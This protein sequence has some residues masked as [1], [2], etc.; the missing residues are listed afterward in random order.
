MSTVT[1]VSGS[2][3]CGKSTL[4]RQLARRSGVGVHL[5]TDEFYRFLAHRLDPSTPES[6]PQN[7]AVLRAFLRAAQSFAQDGY[8]VY[9]DGVIG[10]WWLDTI[11]QIFP[12]F[13]YVLLRAD[14]ATVLHRTS[15]RATADQAS[16]NSILVQTMH[17]QFNAVRGYDRHIIDTAGPTQDAVLAEF[18]EGQSRNAFDY[19][20]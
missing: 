13:A 14:L 7:T 10:P 2:P 3:G 1:I 6:K 16:A 9:V 5:R 20:K 4:S 19:P 11:E 12:R 18:L 15:E 8:D 17:E